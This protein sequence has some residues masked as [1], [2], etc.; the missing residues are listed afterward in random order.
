MSVASWSSVRGMVY[1][2]VI[3]VHQPIF[4]DALALAVASLELGLQVVEETGVNYF[5]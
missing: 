1:H 2:A 4:A 3:A 5:V